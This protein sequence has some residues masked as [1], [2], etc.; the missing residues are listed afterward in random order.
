MVGNQSLA[1]RKPLARLP[2]PAP[3]KEQQPPPPPQPQRRLKTPQELHGEVMAQVERRPQHAPVIFGASAERFSQLARHPEY[4]GQAG[5]LLALAKWFETAAIGTANDFNE[6]LHDAIEAVRMGAPSDLD[7]VAVRRQLREEEQPPRVSISPESFTRDSALGRYSD[8]KYAPTDEEYALGVRQEDTLVIWPGLK[9][10]SQAFTVV[11]MLANVP[12][13]PIIQEGIFDPL[14]ARPYGF[15]E[16]GADGSKT[17]RIK[18]DIGF[19]TKFTVVGSYIA[20][21]AGMA[22]LPNNWRSKQLRLGAH[23]GAFAAPSVAPVTCTEYVDALSAGSDSAF[24]LRPQMATFLLPLQ[25]TNLLG[26]TL[27]SF[28]DFNG[29]ALYRITWNTSTVAAAPIPLS[30]DVAYVRLNN[31]T[32]DEASYRMVFQLSL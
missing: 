31:G 1:H 25:C 26:S 13:L 30:P 19:G 29:T 9:H 2:G 23:I 6:Q 15:V 8:F 3:R 20:V 14:A 27:I 11:A 21:G 32:G 10:E 17:A 18:F 22:P 16:F 7:V 4:G 24:V 5:E 12:E 28:Y